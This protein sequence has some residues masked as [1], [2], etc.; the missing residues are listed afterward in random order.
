MKIGDKFRDFFSSIKHKFSNWSKFDT[1]G[2]KSKR[3]F[4]LALASLGIV[5]L[6]VVA[7]FTGS[8]V[9]GKSLTGFVVQ[10]ESVINNLREELNS[11]QGQLEGVTQELTTKQQEIDSKSEEASGLK[12][13]LSQKESEILSAESEASANAAKAVGLESEV[14]NL[15]SENSDLESE[16]EKI[17]EVVGSSA[18]SLCCSLRDF[19]DGVEKSWGFSGGEIECNSGS[20]T[21][22]CATGDTNFVSD[23]VEDAEA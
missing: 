22:D 7:F 3:K 14:S 9:K 17:S 15:K 6:L 16:N 4:F 18:W 23:S 11:T 12:E 13:Q 1:Q 20:Y 10:Q 21:I 5:V 2:Y 8:T 19:K